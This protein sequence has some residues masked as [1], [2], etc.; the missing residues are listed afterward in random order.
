MATHSNESDPTLFDKVAL[1]F[2]FFV[3]GTLHVGNKVL[4]KLKW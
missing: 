2:L 1:V 4:N 3:Y